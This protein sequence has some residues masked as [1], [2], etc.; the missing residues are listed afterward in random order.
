[1]PLV[2]SGVEYGNLREHAL[3]RLK[4][5][6]QSCRDVRTREV[7]IAEIHSKIRPETAELIRRDYVANGGWET[8]LSYEDPDQDILIGLLRLRKCSPAA[9]RPE[10]TIGQC[11]IVRELHVYGS[12][13]GI[14]DRDPTKFQHQGFGTL[15]MEEA[16]R[17]AREE[18]GSIK[19]AVIS[20]VGTR[21][22]YRKL[23]YELD[24]PY[25]S[26]ML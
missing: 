10:L 2:T 4:D 22:Y 7:G 20:G 16:E 15:L 19:L 23:G 11:S 8:F 12:G 9:F 17:I 5:L 18:H 13:V 24:G 25:M 3:A 6:G 26:K 21:H 1:M 14:H